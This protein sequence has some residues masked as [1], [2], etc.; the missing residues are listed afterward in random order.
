M[1]KTT[2]SAVLITLA[3]L[4]L[5]TV[6]AKTYHLYYL[7]GQSN[8]DG[9]G[10]VEQ[11][12]SQLKG[13]VEDVMI[14]H[15]NPAPDGTP[16]GQGVWTELRP[17][18][19]AGYESDG[20][21]V[22]R[23]DRFG[24][25][26]TFARTLRKLRPQANIAVIKYSRG[27]TSID[28]DAAGRF[29]CW[30][31]DYTLNGGVNQYDSFLATLR[32]AAGVLDIDGDGSRDTLIPA[33]IVW[34]QGESDAAYTE[35]I[36]RRYRSHLTRLMNLIRA[37]LRV[38][39]LPVVIG[40]ISDSGRDEEEND[41]KVWNYGH[42][43][44]AAQEAFVRADTS[45]ALVTTTDNYD[46]SDKWH[47]DTEGYIDLG[48]Q[49]AKAMHRLAPAPSD[50]KQSV[51]AALKTGDFHWRTGP[52]LV[53]P[54]DFADDTTYSIKDPSIVRCHDRWH[55]F[56]TIRGKERSH[57]VVYLTFKDWGQAAGAKQHLLKLHPGY[58]CAPQVFYFTPHN[59]WYMIC[60]AADESWGDPPYRPAFSTSPDI[61]EPDAWSPLQPMFDGKPDG[62]KAWLDFWVICDDARAY[63]FFTSLDGRMWRSQTA[64]ADFPLGWSRPVV[65]LQADVFEASH[66]YSVQGLPY[67]YLTI[68]EAQHGHG[69]R[70]YKAYTADRLD[71]KWTP[72]AGDRENSFASMKNVRQTAA[73]WTDS[74]S[75]GELIRS[76]FDERL[77]VDPA[78]LR[79]LF[80]GVSD[81]RRGGKS[82]GRIPWRLGLLVP[83]QQ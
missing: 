18:H 6:C 32:N 37:A 30:D 61:A 5:V 16:G 42:I 62:P 47:Y 35:P 14:F 1:N 38:D 83:Q 49:F 65:A 31:P 12:P 8:M 55:L 27:G 9:Y 51:P 11:L 3:V 28:Q 39:D 4:P 78:N 80:Q 54:V 71:G 2:V 52:P 76:G 67:N 73:R 48:A 19:G 57:A 77:K 21:T 25:E 81:E 79:M 75:H 41:G 56:C 10:Y 23:S 36:A 60:Q 53:E 20:R 22:S 34:M 29:G 72:L 50:A 15:G 74:I 69:W 33:G 82:Y 68:I 13:P 59:K 40:R 46:Y 63:L 45:A 43:V 7:G 58:Y 26:L 44:R 24:V 70:Y 66:T 64:P 17:G